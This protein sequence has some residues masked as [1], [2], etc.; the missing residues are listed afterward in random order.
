VPRIRHLTT[1]LKAET[2]ELVKQRDR[3]I[4]DPTLGPGLRVNSL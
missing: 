4:A 1:E 2:M 3:T